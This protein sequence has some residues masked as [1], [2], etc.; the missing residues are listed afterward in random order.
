MVKIGQNGIVK[1]LQKKRSLPKDVQA[2]MVAP[3]L[4]D[5]PTLSTVQKWAA[6]CKSLED[7]PRSRCLATITTQENIDRVM[8]MDDR[9]L[10]VNQ[11]ANIVT[12]NE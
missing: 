10:T 6:E 3:L 11:I 9:P 12:M 5:A 1:Y 7:D 8:V 2:D 4:D